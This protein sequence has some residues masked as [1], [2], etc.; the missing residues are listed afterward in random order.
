[1]ESVVV[2]VPVSVLSV[3][4]VS[5]VVDCSVGLCLLVELLDGSDELLSELVDSSGI[6]LLSVELLDGSVDS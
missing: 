4:P 1:M 5:H 3:E 6:V 2:H